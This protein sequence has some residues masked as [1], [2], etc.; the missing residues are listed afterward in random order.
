MKQSACTH[1]Q[2]IAHYLIPEFATHNTINFT[3]LGIELYQEYNMGG[4]ST[5]YS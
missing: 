1:L 4:P 5:Q 3:I 2:F